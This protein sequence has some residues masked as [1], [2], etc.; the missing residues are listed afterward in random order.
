M[1]LGECVA[2]QEELVPSW[3]QLLS[4]GGPEPLAAIVQGVD[5]R[6]RVDVT[7]DRSWEVVVDPA[8]APAD[9]PKEVVLTRFS[10]GA[11]FAFSDR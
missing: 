10:T 7:G 4:A 5:R 6:A 11:D 3:P 9:E 1:A 2:L 8:A